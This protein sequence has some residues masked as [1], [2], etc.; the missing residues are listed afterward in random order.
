MTQKQRAR[1]R[2]YWGM[3]DL[4]RVHQELPSRA[5]I[6]DAIAATRHPITVRYGLTEAG[7]RMMVFRHHGAAD[8]CLWCDEPICPDEL[9]IPHMGW[10]FHELV[11]WPEF[12][13][14]ENA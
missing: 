10:L 2:Q 14:S 11:C 9:V 1:A 6:E 5:T 7:E 12:D 13:T 8:L 3:E 4:S